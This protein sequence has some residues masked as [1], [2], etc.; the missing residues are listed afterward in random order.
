MSGV[1]DTTDETEARSKH[2]P[3]AHGTGKQKGNPRAGLFLSVFWTGSG[4]GE[5]RGTGARIDH[6]RQN[7]DNAFHV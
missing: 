1:A 2:A 6:L 4:R 5:V 7:N 3:G